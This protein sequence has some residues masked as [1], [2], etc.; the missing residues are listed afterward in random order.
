MRSIKDL[1]NEHLLTSDADS[2]E[3]ELPQAELNR[4]MVRLLRRLIDRIESGSLEAVGAN[5]ECDV[6]DITE[7][8]DEFARYEPGSSLYY[9]LK[10]RRVEGA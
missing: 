8:D 9:Y 1:V 4:I 5:V 2:T 7:P 6:V 3:S 10:L